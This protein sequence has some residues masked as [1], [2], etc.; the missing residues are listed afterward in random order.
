MTRG[1]DDHLPDPIDFDPQKTYR[2]PI[3]L[4]SFS[5]ADFTMPDPK[6]YYQRMLNEQGYNEGAGLGCLADYFRDQSGGRLN[7]EFDV[8]GPYK[9]SQ[10]A[11]GHGSRYYG[12]D[13]ISDA[14]TLLYESESTDF[15]IYD[16]N[17]DGEVNQVFFVSASYGGNLVSGY[18]WPCSQTMY[19]KLPGDRKP[20]F[21]SIAT[22]LWTDGTL[23]GFGTIAH[24]I[25]HALGLPDIYP[26]G[27]A[28]AFSAVDEWDLLDG[29]NYTNKGWCPP[30]LSAME[31][32]YL[33]WDQ[34]EELTQTTTVTGMQPLSKGGKTYLIRCSDNSD[35]YYLLENRQ[36]EGWDYG[37]PGKG[38]LIFHVDYSANSWKSNEVNI[39]DT[40]YRYDLSHADGKD[41]LAW[42]PKNNGKDP[43]K[44]TLPN[45][46]RN[47]YLSTS[48]YPYEDNRSLT[49][50]SSIQLANIRQA[51]DGTI[52]FDLIKE[53]TAIHSPSAESVPV[54][55][56]DL[57]GH[58]LPGLP[59]NSGIYII[60]Y[61]D[62]TTKKCVR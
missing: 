58:L 53:A 55:Y 45:C 13:V 4:I 34:P 14:V 54:A 42:D 49:I 51:A 20:H 12:T 26:L 36:Q 8:Y 43:N 23:N 6:A 1:D 41:Y 60:Q 10:T 35:E 29:G 18:I 33:G 17:G 56:Y 7:F 30:N 15:S 3:V 44:W 24:E 2:L 27:E 19:V 47:S 22:E 59:C 38:L 57:K 16:W 31:K 25:C 39:S 48:P 21:C 32:Q 11:G 61:A 52:S 37:S 9:V 62:G 40:H 50:N 5:D 46:L 28:T